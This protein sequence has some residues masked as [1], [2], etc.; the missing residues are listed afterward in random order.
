M[1]ILELVHRQMPEKILNIALLKHVR[2]CTHPKIP[3]D[4]N[5]TRKKLKHQNINKYET[6]SKTYK[7]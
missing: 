6:Y 2:P 5:A 4:R 3:K 7:I 1:I